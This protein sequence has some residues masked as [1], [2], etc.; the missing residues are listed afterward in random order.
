MAI[1]PID[2]TKHAGLT[3]APVEDYSFTA[4]LNCTPL[5][6]FETPDAAC[7]F[8]IAFPVADSAL[9]HALLGLGGKNIFLDAQ[10]RWTAPYIPL[11]VANHPFSIIGGPQPEG[12]D[13]N[14][15]F[16]VGLDD[17]APHFKQKDG[18]A[19]YG[20]DG[21]PAELLQRITNAL[22][23]QF[24]RHKDMQKSLAELALSNVLREQTITLTF[25]GK[26]HGVSGLRVADQKAVMALPAETLG[27][28]AK[29]GILEMLYA[30]WWSI[31]NLRPLLEDAPQTETPKVQ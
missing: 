30:H 19:L 16:F 9:P 23:N 13:K 12:E 28:W 18:Q 31:R 24:R 8:A 14:Q 11:S 3:F 5:M 26:K 25:N 10:G 22:A 29:S 20:P 4:G 2:K 17:E 21:E 27:R 7:C 15:Q 1:V 6:P